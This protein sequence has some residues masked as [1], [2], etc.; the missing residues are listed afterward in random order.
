MESYLERGAVF[1]FCVGAITFIS[2][3]I[4]CISTYGFL[5]GVGLGWLPSIIVAFFAFLLALLVWG[6][7]ALLC[8]LLLALVIIQMMRPTPTPPTVGG[9]VQEKPMVT[10][11]EQIN[12]A[13]E[14]FKASK[15][16]PEKVQE[17]TQP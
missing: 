5:L 9:P 13:V 7:I 1:A 17:P 3:W 6:P 4:Y 10:L 16:A 14:R 11:E 8:V 12:A 2:S 15:P